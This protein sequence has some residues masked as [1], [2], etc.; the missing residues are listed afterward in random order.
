[1]WAELAAN[2]KEPAASLPTEESAPSAAL[3]AVPP[4]QISDV[5]IPDL[6]DLSEKEAQDRLKKRGLQARNVD[7]CSDSDQGELKRKKQSLQ[8]QNLAA[9]TTTSIGTTVE[10]GIRQ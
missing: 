4:T 10:H 5:T 9:N 2:R 8:C 7:T 6:Q 3:T 1:L